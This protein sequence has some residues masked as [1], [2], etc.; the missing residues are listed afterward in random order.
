MNKAT[1]LNAATIRK[2][3]RQLGLTQHAFAALMQTTQPVISKIERGDNKP[4]GDLALRLHDMVV[5][6]SDIKPVYLEMKPGLLKGTAHANSGDTP[7]GTA[8]IGERNHAGDLVLTI[9]RGSPI[10]ATAHKLLRLAAAAPETERNAVIMR[11]E[12]PALYQGSAPPTQHGFLPGL[13][14]GLA[15]GGINPDSADGAR[16]IADALA[17]LEA[18]IDPAQQLAQTAMGSKINRRISN[19]HAGGG[20]GKP[21]LARGKGQGKA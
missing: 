8:I 5:T 6:Q 17:A 3:R 13:R 20:A 16:I 19:V 10:F 18:G 7:P 2:L 11:L 12:N 1:D 9:Q 4:S 14:Q 21:A 15:R